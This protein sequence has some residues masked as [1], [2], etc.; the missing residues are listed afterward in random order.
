MTPLVKL[1]TRCTFV[2]RRRR[3]I[4]PTSIEARTLTRAHTVVFA[5]SFAPQLIVHGRISC[6]SD[7]RTRPCVDIYKWPCFGR[8]SVRRVPR[9]MLSWRRLCCI[10]LKNASRAQTYDRH[11]AFTMRNTA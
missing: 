11:D 9:P 7:A 6:S 5:F 1:I 2:L 8:A 10:G 3:P 4:L